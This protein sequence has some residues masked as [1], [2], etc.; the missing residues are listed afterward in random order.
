MDAQPELALIAR[1]LNE[2]RLEAVLIGN[3]AA[4]LHGAPL[5]TIEID[6]F[7]RKTPRN[8]EKLKALATSMGATILRP[9]P[10]SELFC[11]QRER[12]GLQLNFTG[13][14]DGAKSYEDIRAAAQTFELGGHCLLVSALEVKSKRAAKRALRELIRF[15]LSLPPEKRLNVLRKKIGLTAT[16]L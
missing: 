9:F 13:R 5:L 6:F 16:C 12:D 10:D 3:M 7:F 11:L 4:A 14:V 2:H 1:L 15:R 8:L